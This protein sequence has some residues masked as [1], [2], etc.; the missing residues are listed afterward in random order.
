MSIFYASDK[1]LEKKWLSETDSKKEKREKAKG[2]E[3]IWRN[4][5]GGK[6]SKEGNRRTG[7]NLGKQRRKE[8]KTE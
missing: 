1:A 4:G 6:H 3:E 7:E 2:G 5:R 8:R